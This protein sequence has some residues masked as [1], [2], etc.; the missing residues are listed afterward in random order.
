MEETKDKKNVVEAYVYDMRNKLHDKLHEFV[1]EP[2][3]EAFIAKLQE[4]GCM[5]TVKMKL[6]V[7][8]FP[9]LMSSKSKAILSHPQNPQAE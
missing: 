3:R 9:N 8:T 7:Y 5:K 4:T 1:T 2:E 6:K